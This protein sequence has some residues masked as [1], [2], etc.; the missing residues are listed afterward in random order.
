MQNQQSFMQKII[1]ISWKI[2]LILMILLCF[3][4]VYKIDL[5]KESKDIV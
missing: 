1:S 3:Y 2:L 4:Y 5:K